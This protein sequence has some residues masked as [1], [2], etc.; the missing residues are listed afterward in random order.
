MQQINFMSVDLEDYFCDLPFSMWENYHERVIF[1]TNKILKLFK[2]Y[3]VKATF[4]TLGYIAEK[5]PDLI[6]EI[7]DEGHEIASHSYSHLDLRKN[8]KEKIEEDIEKS[9]RILEDVTGKEVVG[10]RAP[11]FSIDEKSFWVFDYLEKKFVYDSSIFPVK[12]PLYGVPDASTSIY[13]P[14]KESPKIDNPNGKLIEIPLATHK[15]PVYGNVPI[16]GGFHLRFLPYFYI[17]Y[18]IKSNQKRNQPVM[19]YIHP[20]DIDPEMPKIDQYG[21][22]YY[23]NLKNAQKKFECLLKDFRFSSVKEILK[24]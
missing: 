9:I 17:K 21:W 18:G 13:K 11:F 4:F 19:I 1:N 12:T 3:N 2:K 7:V 6:H 14:T 23:Y 24:I 5:F 15:F 10:F 22:Y 20:K 8:S 16:A